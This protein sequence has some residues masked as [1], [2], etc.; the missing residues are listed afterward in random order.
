MSDSAPSA[1]ATGIRLERH[2]GQEPDISSASFVA[3]CAR[4]IGDVRLGRGSSVFYGAVLRAD[5]AAIHIGEGSNVQ[6]GCIIHLADDLDTVVGDDC[7]I[8]HAAI[9]HA[10]RV[11]NTTLIGMRTTILDGAVI[12]EE[13]LVGA[14]ALVTQRMA[15]PSRSLVLGSPAKVVRPLTPRE[16]ES[17]HESAAKYRIVA[18]AHAQRQA[19]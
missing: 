17:L 2:L 11:G 8:G 16:I 1:V 18:R 12:G 3:P 6:D 7:T 13:C 4:I 10:C 19:R 15:V 5:I 14:G 9:L